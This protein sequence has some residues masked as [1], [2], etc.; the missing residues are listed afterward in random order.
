M[1][2]R[3]NQYENGLTPNE[4]PIPLIL[5]SV[6]EV[7]TL[8]KKP[9][10]QLFAEAE[11]YEAMR[12]VLKRARSNTLGSVDDTLAPATPSSHDDAFSVEEQRKQ[13]NKHAT[14]LA[15]SAK[16]SSDTVIPF[17]KQEKERLKKKIEEM[18]D[19]L[20]S[21]TTT[22]SDTKS[23]NEKIGEHALRIHM[24]DVLLRNELLT[25]KTIKEIAKN[26]D[27]CEVL[28]TAQQ[29]YAYVGCLTDCIKRG[30]ILPT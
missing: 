17:L 20:L 2:D 6:G 22:P 10:A 4:E 27:R 23:Y 30:F 14:S 21:A 5:P 15:A 25:W 7:L 16:L 26:D 29:E 24:L 19:E 18:Q 9:A 1:S 28:N 11:T 12:D 3:N 13:L 8:Y